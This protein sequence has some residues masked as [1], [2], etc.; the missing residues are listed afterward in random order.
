[1]S[2]FVATSYLIS[3]VLFIL[4]I[5]GLASPRTARNGNMFGVAGMVLAIL[6]TIA[7]PVVEH[8]LLILL[9]IF[10]G[11]VVGI[12]IALKVKMTAMPQ[13]VAGFHSLVGLKNVFSNVLF[14]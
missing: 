13:L 1:M 11:G 5:Y 2:F 4:A 10:I 6:T 8:K 9:A 12:A 7:L 3:S 14:N